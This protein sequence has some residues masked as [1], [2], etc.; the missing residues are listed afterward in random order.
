METEMIQLLAY[1]KFSYKGKSSESPWIQ[2]DSM[3]SD[4]IYQSF[5]STY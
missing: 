5:W 4:I 2:K 3:S 1:K